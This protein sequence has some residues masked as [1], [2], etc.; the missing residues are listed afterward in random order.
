MQSDILVDEGLAYEEAPPSVAP[1]ALN[2]AEAAYRRA[3]NANDQNVEAYFYRGKLLI[4]DK[5][6]KLRANGKEMLD[7]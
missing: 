5:D 2:K 4:P 3:I 7:K 1:D 6:L